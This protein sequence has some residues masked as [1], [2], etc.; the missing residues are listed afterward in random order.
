MAILFG[1][2]I[3]LCIISNNDGFLRPLRNYDRLQF[4]CS[5]HQWNQHNLPFSSLTSTPS[6]VQQ[7]ST[8][9]LVNANATAINIAGESLLRT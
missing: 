1:L 7:L 8:D 4:T 6:T 3:G 5:G 2:L 9:V